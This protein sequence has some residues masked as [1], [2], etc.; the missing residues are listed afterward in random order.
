MKRY[1]NTAEKN[2]IFISNVSEDQR[3]IISAVDENQT[4]S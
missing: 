4:S 2:F 3:S 1:I